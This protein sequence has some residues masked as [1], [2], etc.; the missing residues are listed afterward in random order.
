MSESRNK[1]TNFRESQSAVVGEY[2]EKKLTIEI[3]VFSIFLV[4]DLDMAME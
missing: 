2:K 4:Q 3:V 1:R